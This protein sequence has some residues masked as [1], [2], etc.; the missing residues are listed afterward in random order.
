MTIQDFP[1]HDGETFRLR[2]IHGQVHTIRVTYNYASAGDRVR[3]ERAVDRERRLAEVVGLA[4]V[5]LGR[6]ARHRAGVEERC[7]HGR[8]AF[9]RFDRAGADVRTFARPATTI[10]S[11]GPSSR[12]WTTRAA[13][14]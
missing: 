3:P 2:D 8:T 6:V 4:A 1:F 13:Y 11:S 9:R 7:V 12:P 5:R 10:T 14:R